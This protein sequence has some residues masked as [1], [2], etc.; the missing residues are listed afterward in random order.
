MRHVI[1]VI[2]T[3]DV[4][5]AVIVSMGWIYSVEFN[6]A[7]CLADDDGDIAFLAD[8]LVRVSVMLALLVCS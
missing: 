8:C 6:A 4:A 1:P 2:L 3:D 5:V 7:G